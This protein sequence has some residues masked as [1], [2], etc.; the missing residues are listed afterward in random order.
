VSLLGQ[1]PS[2]QLS[3]AEESLLDGIWGEYGKL[4]QW[5][6]RD[7][8]HT[9]PE[10]QDPKGSSRPIRI[11]DILLAEGFSEDDVRDIFDALRAEEFAAG[12]EA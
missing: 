6:L 3:P 10:W 4:S 12:L 5:G 9:L 7:F 2:D 11:Q 1:A 8:T